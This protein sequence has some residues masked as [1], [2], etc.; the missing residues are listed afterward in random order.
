MV[1]ACHTQAQ[2]VDNKVNCVCGALRTSFSAGITIMTAHKFVRHKGTWMSNNG[3]TIGTF[4]RDTAHG[5][6]D[7]LANMFGVD[8]VSYYD[9]WQQDSPVAN[10]NYHKRQ[11]R[12]ARYVF[13]YE[14]NGMDHHFAYLDRSTLLCFYIHYS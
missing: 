5:L 2:I 7:E 12:G 1:S 14:E 6:P 10:G 8:A 13:T 11:Q 4:K 9:I 3:M